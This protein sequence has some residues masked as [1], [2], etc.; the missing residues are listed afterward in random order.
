MSDTQ[1]EIQPGEKVLLDA[2]E[3]AA[4]Q[5]ALV[6]C[7]F[8][9]DE[10]TAVAGCGVRLGLVPGAPFKIFVGEFAEL[11]QVLNSCLRSAL[12]R[13]GAGPPG[14]VYR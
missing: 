2:D 13:A 6:R 14:R 10:S 8:P 11:A 3:M 1:H 12:S 7:S 4:I 5:A 9:R